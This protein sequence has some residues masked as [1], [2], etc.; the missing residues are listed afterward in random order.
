MPFQSLH[1]QTEL[2]LTI[3]RNYQITS[4][5]SFLLS[6][7]PLLNYLHEINFLHFTDPTILSS[8]MILSCL[9]P[10]LSA[11]IHHCN[12]FLILSHPYHRCLTNPQPYL[13]PDINILRTTG[14]SV[15]EEQCITW[16]ISHHTQK[17]Q[18][19]T[20]KPFTRSSFS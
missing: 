19:Q 17:E 14:A 18:L 13:N 16:Q 15:C 3:S 11:T 8:S 2:A 5:K 12:Y 20:G 7:Q 10:S 1:D 9:I 4:S 6:F